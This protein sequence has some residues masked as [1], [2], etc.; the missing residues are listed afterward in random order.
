[1]IG[2]GSFLLHDNGT[3][4]DPTSTTYYSKG[5]GTNGN[6]PFCAIYVGPYTI[7]VD[8]PGANTGGTGAFRVKLVE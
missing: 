6:D 7:G 5:P 3:N 4:A 1:V 8:G 2:Y